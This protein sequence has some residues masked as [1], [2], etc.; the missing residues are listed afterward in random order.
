MIEQFLII[1]LKE[2]QAW[3]HRQCPENREEAVALVVHLEKETGRL[4]DSRSAVWYTWRS[5][6][7]LEQCG[8]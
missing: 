5:K 1:F 8:R 3:A 4:R 6:P 7:H 2:I